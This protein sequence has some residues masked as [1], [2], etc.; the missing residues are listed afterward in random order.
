MPPMVVGTSPIFS[1]SGHRLNLSRRQEVTS[2]QGLRGVWIARPS[3]PAPRIRHP[4]PPRPWPGRQLRP[5]LSAGRF[6]GGA[7][8]RPPALTR[9]QRDMR[10]RAP[11]EDAPRA[12]QPSGRP[13]TRSHLPS[14]ASCPSLLRVQHP[15]WHRG[16][17]PWGQALTPL[18]TPESIPFHHATFSTS[19]PSSSSPAQLG[20]GGLGHP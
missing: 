17:L 19:S 10:D 18:S 20:A 6:G 9:G 13:D 15:G 12:P 5:P 8:T 3:S 1:A 7:R 16:V 14:S 4:L 2:A 11:T